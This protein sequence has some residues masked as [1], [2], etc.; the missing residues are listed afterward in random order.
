MEGSRVSDGHSEDKGV[1]EGRLAGTEGHGREPGG[2]SHL[3]TKGSSR[4][5]LCLGGTGEGGVSR[6]QAGMRRKEIRDPCRTLGGGETLS[7]CLWEEHSGGGGD[8]ELGD[9]VVWRPFGGA[10]VREV[11]AGQEQAG[12]DGKAAGL[13]GKYYGGKSQGLV[14]KNIGL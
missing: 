13:L 3:F 14:E 8:K 4:P 9:R 12:G 5:G 1:G 10:V 11:L 6:Q 7:D 2:R